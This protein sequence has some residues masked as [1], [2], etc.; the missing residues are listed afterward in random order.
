MEAGWV[1][2]CRPG[3]AAD[4]GTGRRRHQV[5][6]LEH[7]GRDEPLAG[8]PP[9]EEPVAGRARVSA[10]EGGARVGSLRGA[11]VARVP[12]PRRDGNRWPTGS[13]SWSESG[14]A[15]SESGRPTGRARE[16]REP[17]PLTLPGIRRALR[18]LLRPVAKL[19]CAYCRA[20]DRTRSRCNAVVPNVPGERAQP[21]RDLELHRFRSTSERS[22]SMR[23]ASAPPRERD[24]KRLRSGCLKTPARAARLASCYGVDSTHPY[25][26]KCRFCANE[27]G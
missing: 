4:R 16:K 22:A 6:L 3:V 18:Q 7:A 27:G 8:R 19:D 11:V 9:V 25:P 20:G 13:C 2:R 21:E 15:S 12:P 5:R 23:S 10:D 24:G 14:L 26:F 1:R 17:E